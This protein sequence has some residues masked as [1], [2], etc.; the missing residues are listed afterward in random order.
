LV[1]LPLFEGEVPQAEGVFR[2][3]C[4]AKVRRLA[5]VKLATLSRTFAGSG[6]PPDRRR[7]A[8]EA[9]GQGPGETAKRFPQQNI[10]KIE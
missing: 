5:S 3:G 6:V 7:K 10:F 1:F 4:V 9:G 2:S 8:P